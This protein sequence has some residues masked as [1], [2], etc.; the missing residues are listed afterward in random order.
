MPVLISIYNSGHVRGFSADCNFFW[1]FRKGRFKIQFPFT[2]SEMVGARFCARGSSPSA[3]CRALLRSPPPFAG[4]RWTLVVAAS[5]RQSL[6]FGDQTC[7][8]LIMQTILHW[9]A[10]TPWCKRTFQPHRS[11][12]DTSKQYKLRTFRIQKAMSNSKGDV[13]CPR[14]C[15]EY[16]ISCKSSLSPLTIA[17]HS[18]DG[19]VLMR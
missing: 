16:R 2:I 9:P 1:I 13:E 12:H 11:N 18:R 4:W 7:S 5:G 17:F 14:A 3:L 15:F 19:H 8:R 10:W 6:V